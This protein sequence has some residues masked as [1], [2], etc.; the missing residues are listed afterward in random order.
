M[1]KVVLKPDQKYCLYIACVCDWKNSST[2]FNVHEFLL[3]PITSNLYFCVS[4]ALEYIST[5]FLL[6]LKSLGADF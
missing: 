3:L 2:P 6:N 1:N 4:A 5:V